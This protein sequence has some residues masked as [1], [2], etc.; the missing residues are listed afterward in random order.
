MVP[1][2]DLGRSWPSAPRSNFR[3]GMKVYVEGRL[4]TR[5]WEDQQGQKRYTTEMITA[6]QVTNL[7]RV[8][9][10]RRAPTRR[11]SPARLATG[12][13]QRLADPAPE[14]VGPDDGPSDIDDL[15][16]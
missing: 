16:F 7:E 15:P 3:K 11:R 5:Q 13:R 2:D 6:D 10:A 12:R 4:Q 14:A 9:R 8:G 1:G